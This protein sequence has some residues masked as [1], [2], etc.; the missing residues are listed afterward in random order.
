[1]YTLKIVVDMIIRILNILI[2][3]GI[4]VLDYSYYLHMF[5][6]NSYFPERYRKWRQDGGRTIFQ[7]MALVFR[8]VSTLCLVIL[9]LSIASL[10]IG[11]EQ[12]YSASTFMS[13]INLW[14][15]MNIW[16]RIQKKEK[17][18]KPLVYT[19]R[20]YRL[21]VILLIPFG[22][23][24]VALKLVLPWFLA[25]IVVEFLFIYMAYY[26]IYVAYYLLRPVENYLGNQF[27]NQAK[28]ILNQQRDLIKIGI[29]GSYGKTSTK[30][31]LE[32]VL[33]TKYL[34]L[35]TPHS[36]NTTL[37]VVRTIREHFSGNLEVFVAEM[38][39]KQSGDI[40]EICDLVEPQIGIITAVGPQHLETF[41]SI[42]QVIATKFEL[43]RAIGKNGAVIVNYDDANIRTGMERYPEINYITYGESGGQAKISDI[44]VS[45]QGSSF[46]VTYQDKTMKFQTRLLGKHNIS[47][48]TAGIVVGLYLG[49]APEKIAIGIRETRPVEH[50]L[51]LKMQGNYYIL[52]D[53]FNSNPVG[54][55]NALEV[56]KGFT[57][58]Q[59][60]VMTPGMVELGSEDEKIHF[61][62][63][64]HMAECADIAILVGEKKTA[65]IKEGLLAAGFPQ[66]SIITVPNVFAGF[67]AARECLKAGDILLIENDLPDNY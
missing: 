1:M 30:F 23:L 52:D 62:F 63:G 17:A 24:V 46:C 20:V 36:Y 21:M 2:L 27:Y 49:I 54:A 19:A 53:A 14:L 47:N 16:G 5:Q 33:K 26:L 60:L 50:R 56:L 39:A 64:K 6:L 28:S 67:A 65:K 10:V 37:G 4:F 66:A 44:Q 61:D 11:I 9:I 8:V 12:W 13:L 15:F 18:K 48:L 22:L 51:E 32:N 3:A 25:I 34:T 29:T 43:A 57:N 7:K 35:V 45:E 42:D 38:G 55:N 40:K 58:G 31:I 41:G 59:K